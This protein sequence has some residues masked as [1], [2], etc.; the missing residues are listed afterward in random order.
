MTIHNR[1]AATIHGPDTLALATTETGNLYLAGG[2]VNAHSPQWHEHQ[3]ADQRG[4]L[5][6]DWLLSQTANILNDSTA[7][8]INRCTG[9]L[10]TPDVTAV[11]WSAVTEWTVGEDL[12][13]DHLPITTTIRGDVPA[14]SASYHRTRWNTTNVD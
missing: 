14:A 3:P 12:G 5:V 4:E 8:C 10:S 7:T 1:Y 13:S 9:G 2:D 11:S 6:E